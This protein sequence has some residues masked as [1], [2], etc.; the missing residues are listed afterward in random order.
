MLSIFLGISTGLL[1]FVL[2]AFYKQ[3]LKGLQWLRAYWVLRKLPRPAGP[4]LGGYGSTI[5]GPHRHRVVTELC[6]KFDGVFYYRNYFDQA[7]SCP[8]R[9][10]TPSECFTTPH[11][12]TAAGASTD[13]RVR[14]ES[15]I[16]RSRTCC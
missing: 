11:M 5:V 10:A 2:L 3:V 9:N 8:N 6:E 1:S 4:L 13:T 15:C 12:F 16:D 7:R 14:A